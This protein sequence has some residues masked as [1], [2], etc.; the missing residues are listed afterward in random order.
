LVSLVL[1]YFFGELSGKGPH[2]LCWYMH[3]DSESSQHSYRQGKSLS[4]ESLAERSTTSMDK[5]GRLGSVLLFDDVPVECDVLENLVRSL[6]NQHPRDFNTELL[7]LVA[8]IDS[9]LH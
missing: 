1:L 3:K 8:R 2:Y 7:S 4:N 5:H 6:L 9:P